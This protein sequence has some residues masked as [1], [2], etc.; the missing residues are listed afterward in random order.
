MDQFSRTGLLLGDE[1]M[2][3]IASSHVAVFG[4]GGVGGYVVEALART[5]VGEL[6]IVDADDVDI[7]NL[8]RQIIATHGTVG[9][10]KVEVMAERIHDINPEA[11]VN[12]C[13]RFFLPENAAEFDFAGYGYVV[14][15]VDTVTAK[16]AIVMAAKEAGTP[17]VSAMGAAGKLDP[18]RLEVADIYSTSVCPLA[19]EMRRELRKRGVE[20]LKVVYSKEPP[21]KGASYHLDA[22]G[23]GGAGTDGSGGGDRR[24]KVLGSTA[25]VPAAMGLAIASEVTRDLAGI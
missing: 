8:N 2:E 23:E 3:R 16:L 20:S 4:V 15:A 17:V 22:D 11:R 25:F 21:T 13:Q 5:G 14:D 7:T 10:P 18:T 9:R 12:A 19:R 6:T 1:A 24:S